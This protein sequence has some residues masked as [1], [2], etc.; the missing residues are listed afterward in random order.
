MAHGVGFAFLASVEKSTWYSR[1][2]RMAVAYQLVLVHCGMATVASSVVVTRR[3]RTESKCC[4]GG[5]RNPLKSTG[6]EGSLPIS[7]ACAVF[8]HTYVY[9]P[10]S[11]LS[12]GKCRKARW[13]SYAKLRVMDSK[14]DLSHATGITSLTAAAVVKCSPRDIGMDNSITGN[15]DMLNSG[16]PRGVHDD[17]GDG[18]EP[19]L[20]ATSPCWRLPLVPQCML[21]LLSK[22][23]HHQVAW[24]V[25]QGFPGVVFRPVVEPAHL[26]AIAVAS[27][28]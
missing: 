19:G 14:V 7:V 4:T 5:T 24:K 2:A 6:T 15:M 26:S 10:Y 17:V 28:A 25:L 27:L 22:E 20:S 21:L 23:A 8:G 16:Y 11:R 9:G 12:R 3:R 13:W 18:C 1:H